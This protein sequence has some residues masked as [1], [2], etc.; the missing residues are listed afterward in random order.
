MDVY[1]TTI[2]KGNKTYVKYKTTLY[3]GNDEPVDVLT[4]VQTVCEILKQNNALLNTE[5]P[6]QFCKALL[7]VLDVCL[8]F[9]RHPDI[10][11]NFLLASNCY[12]E[13]GYKHLTEIIEKGYNSP[14][15]QT[16]K[17]LSVAKDDQKAFD[18]WRAYI[19]ERTG[20]DIGSTYDWKKFHGTLMKLIPPMVNKTKERN[21]MIPSN[22]IDSAFPDAKAQQ[23]RKFHAEDK[24]GQE[25]REAISQEK[26]EKSFEQQSKATPGDKIKVTQYLFSMA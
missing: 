11:Q 2:K 1:R 17:E 8:T 9:K 15:F 13:N 6:K 21:N 24:A 7:M 23:A 5:D 10:M 14:V 26:Y 18:K 4:Y 25:A 22:M 20:E 16:K 19:K 3:A 12:K